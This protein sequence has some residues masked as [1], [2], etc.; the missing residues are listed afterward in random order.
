LLREWLQ[1]KRDKGVQTVRVETVLAKLDDEKKLSRRRNGRLTVG[2]DELLGAWDVA[3][4]LQVDRTRPSK[5]RING[6]TFGAEKIPFPEPFA[7]ISKN[8]GNGTP[9]WLRSQIAP[10]IPFVEERR[11]PKA[12][13]KSSRKTRAKAKS[14]SA[15]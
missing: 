9:V 4:L 7:V 12:R 1:E 2:A 3:E 8:E 11:R 6:T 14:A 15:R 10:L 13:P 5:W